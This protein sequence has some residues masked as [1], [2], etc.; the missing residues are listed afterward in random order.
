MEN[1]LI[2]GIELKLNHLVKKQSNGFNLVFSGNSSSIL[3]ENSKINLY[4]TLIEQL[5]FFELKPNR[6]F[7]NHKHVLDILKSNFIY[8][9]Q[10]QI[11]ITIKQKS[12]QMVIFEGSNSIKEIIKSQPIVTSPSELYSITIKSKFDQEIMR[13]VQLVVKSN[14]KKVYFVKK[15]A[16][17]EYAETLYKIKNPD[18]YFMFRRLKLFGLTKNE[19]INKLSITQISSLLEE[20]MDLFFKKN[21]INTLESI[22]FF[23]DNFNSLEITNQKLVNKMRKIHLDIINNQDLV[24]F[25]PKN[26]TFKKQGGIYES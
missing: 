8:D 3:F 24:D 20:K 11:D 13:V 22:F 1:S 16:C 4:L 9:F 10:S 18:R 14:Y 23:I 19:L 21:N 26:N 5:N 25:F 17:N 6:F 12:N 15:H 7:I 2:S